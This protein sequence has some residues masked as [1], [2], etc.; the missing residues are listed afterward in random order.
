MQTSIQNGTA[1]LEIRSHPG[2]VRAANEDW[3]DWRRLPGRAAACVLCDGVGGFQHGAEAARSAADGFL[4]TLFGLDGFSR[5]SASR[6]GLVLRRRISRLQQLRGDRRIATTLTAALLT[7]D[8]ALLWHVG[9]SRA[10]LLRDGRLS[11]LTEDHSQ[12]GSGNHVLHRALGHPEREELDQ[13]DLAL[14]PGDRLLLCSDGLERAGLDE[15]AI[16]ACADADGAT[17]ADRLL[18]RALAG[19]APDNVSFAILD[20][21]F[22]R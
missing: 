20:G 8:G 5:P 15:D 14:E 6:L 7:P 10:W 9:D 12:P 16:L 19:G 18:E 4:E 1:G 13:L 3:V 22:W 21:E 17:F 2:H 11:R